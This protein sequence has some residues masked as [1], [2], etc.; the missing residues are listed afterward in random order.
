MGELL[1]SLTTAELHVWIEYFKRYPFDDLHRHHR[2]AALVAR[3]MSGGEVDELLD[4][5]S[6]Q[7]DG[8]SAV[9]KSVIRALGG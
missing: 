1:G 9:D 3:A 5:L 7:P 4:W 8:M 2:P 6:P